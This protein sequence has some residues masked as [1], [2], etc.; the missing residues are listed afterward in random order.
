MYNNIIIMIDIVIHIVHGLDLS[1][2][3]I[4]GG[5]VWIGRTLDGREGWIGWI[6]RLLESDTG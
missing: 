4:V 6:G 2:T 1:G 3:R 5:H